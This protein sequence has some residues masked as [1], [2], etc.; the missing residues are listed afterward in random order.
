MVT[1]AAGLVWAI[2]LRALTLHSLQNHKTRYKLSDNKR[3]TTLTT[4]SS[5]P[6]G[7]SAAN[8]A[9]VKGAGLKN[10][11]TLGIGGTRDGS[12]DRLKLEVH[13]SAMMS[14]CS[15]LPLKNLVKQPPIL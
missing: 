4:T 14:S 9:S 1:G 12:R 6:E 10:S 15:Q 8:G 11:S 5:S 13:P 3:H 7:A 2:G